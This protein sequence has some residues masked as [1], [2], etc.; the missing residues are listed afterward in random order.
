VP[1]S[2]WHDSYLVVGAG[3]FLT[4]YAMKADGSVQI[5][6]PSIVA[7]SVSDCEPDEKPNGFWCVTEGTLSANGST[8]GIKCGGPYFCGSMFYLNKKG[9]ICT[10]FNHLGK[11]AQCEDESRKVAL[12]YFKKW[13]FK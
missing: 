5:L 6:R 12:A 4:I 10:F 11:G 2:S 3:D 13:P 7:G 9:K 1:I 8:V